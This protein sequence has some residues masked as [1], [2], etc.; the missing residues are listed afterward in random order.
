MKRCIFLF[1]LLLFSCLL[2]SD[3]A[4]VLPVQSGN[5]IPVNNDDIQLKDEQIDIYLNRKSYDVEVNYTFVNRGN[6]QEVIMGF[7]N[8]T[9]SAYTK[10]IQGFR[11]YDGS[12]ELKIFRKDKETSKNSENEQWVGK[13]FYECFK[14]T[15]N[16]GEVK[17]IKNRYSQE[18][19]TNYYG[20]FRLVEYILKTGALWK[21]KIE[22]IKVVIHVNIPQ[23]EL[24]KKTF[25]FYNSETAKWEPSI[26]EL[27][28]YPN[29]YQWNGKEIFMNFKNIEPDFDIRLELQPELIQL[30]A[31]SQLKSNNPKIN[32]L[33]ENVLDGRPETAWVE[34]KKDSGI[35]EYID[36]YMS[37]TSRG[38]GDGCLLVEKIGIINGYGANS[39]LFMK[40]NRVKKIK[41]SYSYYM[42]EEL[43][44][45][46]DMFFDLKDSIEMQYIVFPK[47]LY[48]TQCRLTILD[49]YKGS[50]YNDTCISE[51]KLFSVPEE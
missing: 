22:D 47:P 32:Y 4:P 24:E 3:D 50:K 27:K 19:G 25:Y 5:V 40:N 35:G 13:E 12:R 10:T 26:F 7:P 42:G 23:H 11:A 34:G 38:E 49:V 21:D 18:Y 30:S 29:E 20:S 17:K 9:S 43:K 44:E 14:I 8:K 37:P 16:K 46:K 51:I 28:I 48:M 41:L 15:F 39:D 6:K 1:I 45:G 31:S 33:P 36:L 2:F